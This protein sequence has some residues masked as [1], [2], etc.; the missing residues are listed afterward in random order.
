MLT[1]QCYICVMNKVKKKQ[2]MFSLLPEVRK[3]EEK[4]I[5]EAMKKHNGNATLIA[6]EL[7]IKR[8][9]YYSRVKVLDI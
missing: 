2:V 5:R 7:G 9:T 6:K 4:L 8:T 3:Y 1:T